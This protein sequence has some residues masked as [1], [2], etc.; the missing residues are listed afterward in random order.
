[1]NPPCTHI[2]IILLLTPQPNIGN[3][4]QCTIYFKCSIIVYIMFIKYQHIYTCWY[5]IHTNRYINMC[6]V[7]IYYIWYIIYYQIYYTLYILNTICY[8]IYCA[9][10]NQIYYY[11]SVV[12]YIVCHIYAIL[13]SII[14]CNVLYII[15]FNYVLYYILY[16]MGKEALRGKW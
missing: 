6:V 1:M 11:L 7:S 4:C 9:L 12:S 3:K 15:Y 14:M 13:Y 16:I 10:Y 2:Y 8:Q 5:L